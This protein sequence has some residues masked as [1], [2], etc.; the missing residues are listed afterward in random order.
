MIPV[1]TGVQVWLATGHMDMRKGFDGL[2]LM[3]QEKPCDRLQ[4]TNDSRDSPRISAT[5]DPDGHT[6]NLDLYDAVGLMPPTSALSL[7]R[8]TNTLATR[9]IDDGWHKRR[10][11]LSRRYHLTAPRSSAPREQLL[12]SEPVTTRDVRNYRARCQRFFDDPRL[13]VIRKTAPSPRSRDH[14][15]PTNAARLR[16]KRMVK[17][18][19][20]PISDSE[21]AHPQPSPARGTRWG[22]NTAYSQQGL[23]LG[24]LAVR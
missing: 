4:R 17:R 1:P 24:E 7:G 23:Q 3:V 5:A 19:H 22:H 20:K 15:Q 21:I 16:L 2:A 9:L 14:F 8:F 6:V 13:V 10:S 11:G 12:R 18:R